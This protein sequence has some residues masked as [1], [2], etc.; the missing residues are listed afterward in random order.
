MRERFL[1]AASVL[2][3]TWTWTAKANVISGTFS[4]TVTVIGGSVNGISV[5]APVSGFFSYDPSLTILESGHRWTGLADPAVSFFV[6]INGQPFAGYTALLWGLTFSLDANG[7]PLQGYSQGTWDLSFNGGTL[8]LVYSSGGSYV[9]AQV[10][11]A[12]PEAGATWPLLGVA[13]AGLAG[14]KRLFR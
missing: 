12:V 6:D 4:G 2:L 14:A 1:A 13:L 7:A 11:Y 10:T 9:D 8:G 3:F 5:G